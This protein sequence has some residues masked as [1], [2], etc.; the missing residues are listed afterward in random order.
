MIGK[1]FLENKKL[2]QDFLPLAILLSGFAFLFFYWKLISLYPNGY[3]GLYSLMA[4]TISKN[5]FSLPWTIPFY[6]PGGIPFAYP[7]LSFYLMAVFTTYLK[8]S[9]FDYMRFAPSFFLLA[10]LIPVF[11]LTKII[12]SSSRAALIASFLVGTSIGIISYSYDSAG[13]CRGLALLTMLWE[14]FFSYQA[15]LSGKPRYLFLAA[16]FLAFTILTHLSYAV[17]GFACTLVYAI[18]IRKNTLQRQFIFLLSIC[19]GAMLISMPWWFTVISRYGVGVFWN[20]LNS[21][22]NTTGISSL[23]NILSFL[24]LVNSVFLSSNETPV[25]VFFA[26]VG[27][28]LSLLFRRLFLPI[29]LIITIIA[30]GGEGQRFVA[31]VSAILGA[32]AINEL[33]FR[34][35]SAQAP[36]WLL[37]RIAKDLL[38][39][40]C[41]VVAAYVIRLGQYSSIY[42][43]QILLTLGISIVVKPMVFTIFGLYSGRPDARR[44]SAFTEVLVSGIVSSV[45]MTAILAGLH[46]FHLTS[47]RIPW[48]I[49]VID[50]VLTFFLI[51]SAHQAFIEFKS[52]W[53]VLFPTALL[54]CL[55]GLNSFFVQTKLYSFDIDQTTA[56]FSSAIDLSQWIQT[57]EP[58]QA[59]FLL[60]SDN[61]AEQEWFPYLMKRIP[62]VSFFGAEWD[63]NY[64]YQ[65]FLYQGMVAC[66]QVQSLSCLQSLIRKQNIAMDLLVIPVDPQP[67]SIYASLYQDSG[68]RMLYSNKGYSIWER[69]TTPFNPEPMFDTFQVSPDGNRSILEILK[70][71]S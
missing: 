49:P 43:V 12:S 8:I 7:P 59:T 11:L 70:M 17:F 50:L 56:F 39:F 40:A 58:P 57:H 47:I 51:G 45:L 16:L 4:E 48:S 21:H 5:H 19:L 29:W 27:L 18:F 15:F 61:I 44:M 2:N 65:Y 52:R 14:M 64:T 55:L 3:A 26:I 46:F 34:L 1:H 6:G 10:S 30:T 53:L 67:T 68:W 33:Y 22:S 41:S 69:S 66:Y 35:P 25:L 62:A 24:H 71:G 20:A 54:L 32:L 28:L 13:I 63:G 36:A 38:L 23:T 60:A 31:I 42:V 37:G 9:S